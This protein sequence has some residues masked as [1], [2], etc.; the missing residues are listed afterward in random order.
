MQVEQRFS[1]RLGLLLSVLGIAVGT[2]NIWRFPR[3]AA[4]NS[5]EAG[6]GAFLIAWAIFLLVW[7][8]PLIIS[9]YALGRKGR[10]GL[11]GTFAKIVGERYAWMGAF[12][13][14]VATAIM[15]YDSVVAGWCVFYC[16]EMLTNPLPLTT[17]AS[18]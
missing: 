18:T 7:S 5:G 8:I 1:S 2:G 10:M 11:I 3:I 13:G 15:L 12:I 16:V 6:A 17:E 4:E 14:F 9:E